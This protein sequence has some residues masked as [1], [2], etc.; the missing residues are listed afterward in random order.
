MVNHRAN[1]ADAEIRRKE[2]LDA[3]SGVLQTLPPEDRLV[4]RMRFE[5]GAPVSDIAR[6]LGLPTVFHVYRR[7]TK[8]CTGLRAQLVRR[9]VD[10]PSP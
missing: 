8:I 3:L 9:G 1:G 4:L 6:T 10:G 2:L 7:L 5:D